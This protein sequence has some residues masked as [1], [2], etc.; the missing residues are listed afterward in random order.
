LRGIEEV[1]ADSTSCTLFSRLHIIG[2][3]SISA[4]VITAP[5]NSAVIG[6]DEFNILRGGLQDISLLKLVY[7]PVD[8]PASGLVDADKVN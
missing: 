5:V 7:I 2:D 4:E 1:S 6:T 3:R 8:D